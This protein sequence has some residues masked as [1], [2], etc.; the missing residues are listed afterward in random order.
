ME[1]GTTTQTRKKYAPGISFKPNI[2][3]GF[4]RLSRVLVELAPSTVLCAGVRV[5]V[6]RFFFLPFSEHVLQSTEYR[7]NSILAFRIQEL[8]GLTS[9]ALYA[10]TQEQ[11]IRVHIVSYCV[12]I[13]A[14]FSRYT[15]L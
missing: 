5:C 3:L 2:F 7:P 11:L 14:K 13:N 12:I 9:F 15:E 6:V 4:F 10:R 8:N 1:D